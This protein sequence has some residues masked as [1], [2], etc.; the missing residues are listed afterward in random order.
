MFIVTD[1]ETVMAGQMR[2]KNSPRTRGRRLSKL[3]PSQRTLLDYIQP[4]SSQSSLGSSARDISEPSV[5][6]PSSEEDPEVDHFRLMRTHIQELIAAHQ[7][8][9]L[10]DLFR[11]RDRLRFS[12]SDIRRLYYEAQTAV[13]AEFGA[14]LSPSLFPDHVVGVQES[15]SDSADPQSSQ[16][17]NLFF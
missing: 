6:S 8:N 15:E 13:V 1:H 11:M 17:P 9:A 7:L 2:L 3:P 14:P 12:D 5:R 10:L 16:L 4:F